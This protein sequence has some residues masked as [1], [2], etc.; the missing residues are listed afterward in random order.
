MPDSC[1]GFGFL[2]GGTVIFNF[3]VESV[4]FD[5]R[6][7]K[8]EFHELCHKMRSDT[9]STE[10]IIC[11]INNLA[12][13]TKSGRRLPILRYALANLDKFKVLYDIWRTWDF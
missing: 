3:K 13:T 11:F 1:V 5:P 10:M 8:E 4:E 12:K 7:G 9:I 2:F 6:E